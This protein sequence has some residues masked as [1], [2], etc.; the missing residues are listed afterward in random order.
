MELQIS[1]IKVHMKI[2]GVFVRLSASRDANPSP[3]YHVIRPEENTR[4]KIQWSKLSLTRSSLLVWEACIKEKTPENEGGDPEPVIVGGTVTRVVSGMHQIELRDFYADTNE[5]IGSL[6]VRLEGLSTEI[7]D[8]D[9]DDD[10]SSKSV[11]DRIQD[12]YEKYYQTGKGI[13]NVGHDRYMRVPTFRFYG[14]EVQASYLSLMR[15]DMDERFARSLLDIVLED[16]GMSREN[17][18]KIG[19]E[20]L[21]PDNN[22]W[23]SDTTAI[24]AR[25]GET[26]TLTSNVFRYRADMSS[27][28]LEHRKLIEKIIPHVRE[29]L[30]GDCEDLALEIYFCFCALRELKN[31][32]DRA[33]RILARFAS[34]YVPFIATTVATSPAA[35]GKAQ[36]DLLHVFALA[37]TLSEVRIRL[38]SYYT[39][40]DLL[41]RPWMDH[42]PNLAPLE[43]TNWCDALHLP[44]DQFYDK[45]EKDIIARNNLEELEDLARKISPETRSFPTR[46]RQKIGTSIDIKQFSSFY[47]RI[48]ELWTG[49]FATIDEEHGSCCFSVIRSSTGHF[50]VGLGLIASKAEDY[51]LQPIFYHTREELDTIIHTMRSV[52]P[53][54]AW[55]GIIRKT[56]V[57]G[58]NLKD[59]DPIYP[60]RVSRL[61]SDVIVFHFR[62]AKLAGSDHVQKALHKLKSQ[63]NLDYRAWEFPPEGI[64]KYVAVY[65]SKK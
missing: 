28:A 27:P 55:K 24:I 16:S 61:Y 53:V 47:R 11:L 7:D 32:K 43:G 21:M 49:D 37:L 52:A 30:G 46:I 31:A 18:I 42:L 8:D 10:I 29:E 26:V 5:L 23:L 1:L 25:L 51:Q 58:M 54:P 50:G 40:D 63:F 9:D 33:V 45:L 19:E 12:R 15:G 36:G 35:G 56:T 17:F 57:P 44:I 6:S 62:S 38:P 4:I 41:L 14:A 39:K 3:Y 64:Q 34:L 22:I 48:T 13:P 59:G 60:Q 20:Q 2:P 65:V